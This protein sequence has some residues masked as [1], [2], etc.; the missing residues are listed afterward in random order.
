MVNGTQLATKKA[1]FNATGGVGR[2]ELTIGAAVNI[3]TCAKGTFSGLSGEIFSA[4]KMA[5]NSITFGTCTV[6]STTNCKGDGNVITM[7]P[8]EATEITLDGALGVRGRFKPQ[9]KETLGIVK[10]LGELC[11]FAGTQPIKG[12]LD[13]LGSEGQDEETQQLLTIFSLTN[14][15]KVGSNEGSLLFK[16]TPLL[17]TGEPW[18]FL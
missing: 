11:A 17:Q 12:A 2:V 5:I 8:F 13:F 9:T 16:I 3:V 10:L 18:S 4:T 15:I 6:E 14:Q 1:P 7:L